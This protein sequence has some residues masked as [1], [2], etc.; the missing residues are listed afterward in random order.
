MQENL[1]FIQMA[2]CGEIWNPYTEIVRKN[3]DYKM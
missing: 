1:Y 3:H 2:E